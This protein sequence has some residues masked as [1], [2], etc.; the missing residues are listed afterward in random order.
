ME[1]LG[2]GQRDSL[3]PDSLHGFL[4][5]RFL[6]I[7]CIGDFR[8]GSQIQVLVIDEKPLHVAK[9]LDEGDQFY[10]VLL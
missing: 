7:Q 2:A 9:T 5:F 1:R 3:V 6:Y 10:L 8:V 4:C